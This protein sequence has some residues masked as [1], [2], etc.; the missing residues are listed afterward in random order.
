[1]K[2]TLALILTILL[3]FAAAARA[4]TYEEWILDKAD[5][6][7]NDLGALI[8]D[9]AFIS[10]YF[11]G[12]EF[13]E[14]RNG[15]IAAPPQRVTM[16]YVSSDAQKVRQELLASSVDVSDVALR[17]ITDD[18]TEMMARALSSNLDVISLAFSSVLQVSECFPMPEDFVPLMALI[19]TG[20]DTG[21]I[22]T[23]ARCGEG[24]VRLTLRGVPARAL[25][26]LGAIEAQ[27]GALIETRNWIG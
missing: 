2:K 17:M 5:A 23:A 22:L 3:L 16:V 14:L 24:I 12:N 27:W 25:D 8:A 4:Q 6:M 1:M 21:A 10:L 15:F 19:D 13:E 20:A 9:D 18:L 7:M 26:G 11:S